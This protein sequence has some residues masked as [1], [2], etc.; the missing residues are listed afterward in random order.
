MK[1]AAAMQRDAA[2]ETWPP[3]AREALETIRWYGI[4]VSSKIHRALTGAARHRDEHLE[5]DWRQ[6]DWNGSAK[7]ARL[8]IAESRAAWETILRVGRAPADS[9]LRPLIAHLDDIDAALASRFPE[10]PAFVRPGFDEPER[11]AGG[12][13]D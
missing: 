13:C 1:L 3:E 9:P 5:G 10:A 2:I 6:S 7:V 11:R 12:G 4:R 8:E